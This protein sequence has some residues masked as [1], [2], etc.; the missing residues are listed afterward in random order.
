M[1]SPD[2]IQHDHKPL[3]IIVSLLSDLKNSPVCW[4]T[5][6]IGVDHI[7]QCG[8]LYANSAGFLNRFK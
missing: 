3:L 8:I 2:E 7:T 5:L 4:P 6:Y 1:V